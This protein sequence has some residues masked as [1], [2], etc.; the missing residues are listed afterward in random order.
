METCHNPDEAKEKKLSDR[1][2]WEEVQTQSSRPEEDQKQSEHK[3]VP[4]Y[5]HDN[6]DTSDPDDD[7]D[8]QSTNETF[9]QNEDACDTG[10]TQETYDPN[11]DSLTNSITDDGS[12]I[13]LQDDN[14]SENQNTNE[15]ETRTSTTTRCGRTTRAPDR[16]TL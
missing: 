1:Y 4:F 3:E 5:I 7:P 14:E 13:L 8:I 9:D 2:E 16:L 6:L 15:Y 12:E 10:P 11:N